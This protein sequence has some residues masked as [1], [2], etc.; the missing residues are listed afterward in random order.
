MIPDDAQALFRRNK[1]PDIRGIEVDIGADEIPLDIIPLRP[2]AE[3]CG[4]EIAAVHIVERTAN[5]LRRGID[6]R[7][8]PDIRTRME[9]DNQPELLRLLQNPDDL[10]AVN[11]ILL[12][13]QMQLN[14]L[15]SACGEVFEHL[16]C[17]PV[18][19]VQRAERDHAGTADTLGVAVDAFGLRGLCCNRQANA[20]IDI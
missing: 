6:R 17:F 1:Q 2:A 15:E 20:A 10:R 5:L 9:Y 7:R 16:L 14:S 12:K 11:I 19:G 18:C 4:D 3:V 8:Q 13:L